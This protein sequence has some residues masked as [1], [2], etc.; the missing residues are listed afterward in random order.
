MD[1]PVASFVIPLAAS[2]P[3]ADVHYIDVRGEEVTDSGPVAGTPAECK[4]TI[5]KPTAEPG[6]FCVY[7]SEEY[8]VEANQERI[9]YPGNT[10]GYSEGAGTTGAIVRFVVTNT[11]G[12]ASGT[13]A[14]TAP[15]AS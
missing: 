11:I 12:H 7:G 1:V 14:V 15:A 13:W 2:L 9:L 3:E 6:N 4:G 8:G 10:G 5:E